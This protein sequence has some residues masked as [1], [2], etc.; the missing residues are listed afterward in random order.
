MAFTYQLGMDAKLYFASTKFTGND[1]SDVEGA[2]LT[3]VTNAMN[4]TVNLE[5]GEADITTRGNSGWRATAPTL[6]DGTI[7]FE[8]LCKNPDTTLQSIRNAWL[9]KSEIGVVALT[10]DVNTGGHEGP[11]GNFTVTN[12]S[13]DESLEEAVKYSVSLKPSSQMQWYSTSGTDF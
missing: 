9:N 13:R 2:S 10:G 8:M 5:A 4:V 7:E 12:L 6:K 3:E 11:A 1:P